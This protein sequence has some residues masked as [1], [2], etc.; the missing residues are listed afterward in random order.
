MHLQ[1]LMLE[2]LSNLCYPIHGILAILGDAQN[3]INRTF[4]QHYLMHEHPS[5]D[6]TSAGW[7]THSTRILYNCLSISSR[8]LETEEDLPVN[9]KS[10]VT[11]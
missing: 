8:E 6:I 7:E 2:I 4:N 10:Y 11:I 3:A 1:Y 5:L 9:L